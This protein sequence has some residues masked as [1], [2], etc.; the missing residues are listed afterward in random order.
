MIPAIKTPNNTEITALAGFIPRRKEAIEPVQAPV[1]GRGMATKIINPNTLY[2]SIKLLLDLVC[3][4][5]QLKNLSKI[6][7]L[8]LRKS[9]I[10]PKRNII[11]IGGIILPI[12]DNKKDIPKGILYTNKASGRD[13]LS[14]PTGVIAR[15]KTVKY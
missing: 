9:D 12:Y 11:S 2:L 3:L 1:K 6:L 8:L 15:K 13:N 5:S 10:G 4:K 7:N 14:S